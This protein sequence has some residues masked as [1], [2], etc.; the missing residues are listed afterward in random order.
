MEQNQAV[1]SIAKKQ[2]G[3]SPH[4]VSTLKNKGETKTAMEINICNINF[5]L[6]AL[7]TSEVRL[8]KTMT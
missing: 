5:I 7:C 6:A 8:F 2:M 1:A 3:H 4:E